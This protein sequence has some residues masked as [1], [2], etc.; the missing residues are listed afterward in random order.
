M[1][2]R[3]RIVRMVLAYPA[4]GQ[5]QF[6]YVGQRGKRPL[7]QWVTG[8]TEPE[9]V[10]HLAAQGIAV[11]AI[12]P[13]DGRTVPEQ[14]RQYQRTHPVSGAARLVQQA[15]DAP[16]K[17][18]EAAKAAWNRFDAQRQQ[19]YEAPSTT[20]QARDQHGVRKKSD[21]FNWKAVD[22]TGR[23]ISGVSKPGQT[24]EQLKAEMN[25]KGWYVYEETTQG[26]TYETPQ[27]SGRVNYR[28]SVVGPYGVQKMVR[29]EASTPAEAKQRLTE[30]GYRVVGLT[31]GTS[32]PTAA[33]P[34]QQP[35]SRPSQPSQPIP[36]APDQPTE[37][38]TGPKQKFTFEG[39]DQNGRPVRLRQVA[40]TAYEAMQILNGRGFRFRITR[41]VR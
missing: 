33:P 10:K 40:R 29:V 8:Y 17:L 36:L 38:P 39:Y 35:L 31:V 27:Q 18:G 14:I 24:F 1:T 9:T 13:G 21:V 20:Q 7:A 25:P 15:R 4:R 23:E 37:P 19:A 12:A 41:A 26:A 34:P 22:H 30:A 6:Y 28:A 2:R 5:Q 32:T 3:A 11:Q 16:G